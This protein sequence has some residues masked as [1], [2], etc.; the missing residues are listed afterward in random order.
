MMARLEVHKRV[1]RLWQSVGGGALLT[2]GDEERQPHTL[3]TA[4]PASHMKE[5]IKEME[6]MQR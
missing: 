6:S 5:N 4:Q 1:E 2:D 3:T